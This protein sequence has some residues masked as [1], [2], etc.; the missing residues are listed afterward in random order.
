MNSQSKNNHTKQSRGMQAGSET[1]GGAK[2]PEAVVYQN[3]RPNMY[4]RRW[5][6]GK[7]QGVTF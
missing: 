5:K 2:Q 3:N 4:N 6:K 7:I 1:H